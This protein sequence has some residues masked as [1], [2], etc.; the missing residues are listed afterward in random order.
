MFC[1]SWFTSGSGAPVFNTDSNRGWSSERRGIEC[2]GRVCTLLKPWQESG[3]QE[4]AGGARL[5]AGQLGCV[6]TRG[7]AP[8]PG[9]ASG[10]PGRAPCPFKE[11]GRTTRTL[12]AGVS[13]RTRTTRGEPKDGFFSLRTRAAVPA[14]LGG[15]CALVGLAPREPARRPLLR[16]RPPGSRSLSASDATLP[17]PVRSGARLQRP[18]CPDVYQD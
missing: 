11:S 4:P 1:N 16:S 9:A 3:R 8:P 15:S 14:P 2:S 13:A 17:R 18:Q 5:R 12:W 7:S 6:G 10:S